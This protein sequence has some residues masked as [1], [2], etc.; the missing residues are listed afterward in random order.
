MRLAADKISK[1]KIIGENAMNAFFGELQSKTFD[2]RNV[3]CLQT[4]VKDEKGFG[5]IITI[6]FRAPINDESLEDTQKEIVYDVSQFGDDLELLKEKK[7]QTYAE[8]QCM[9]IAYYLQKV[10]SIEILTMDCEFLLDELENVWFSFA[11]KI[12]F[13]RSKSAQSLQEMLDLKQGNAQ[14]Q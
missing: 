3:N 7:Y 6:Y 2:A 1:V 10:R 5:E 4:T 12:Q 8:K 14:L 13:R 9:K 11:Q